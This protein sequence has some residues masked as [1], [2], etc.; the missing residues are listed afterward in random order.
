M[1]LLTLMLLGILTSADSL[2]FMD[3]SHYGVSDVVDPVLIHSAHI[4]RERSAT[5]MPDILHF[6]FELSDTEV[7]LNL[8]RS[9]RDIESYPVYLTDERGSTLQTD[10]P[11]H[12]NTAV[13]RNSLQGS[14][15]IITRKEAD[16]YQLAGTIHHN[17]QTYKIWPKKHHVYKRQA[18]ES[19]N[20]HMVAQIVSF[21]LTND[22]VDLQLETPFSVGGNPANVEGTPSSVQDSPSNVQGISNEHVQYTVELAI[23]P[24]FTDY[25]IFLA[26]AEGNTTATISNMRLYYAFVQEM[27]QIRYDTVNAQ[28]PSISITVWIK[29]INIATSAAG[30]PWTETTKNGTVVPAVPALLDHVQF[31]SANAPMSAD[32]YMIFTR[33]DLTL[34]GSPVIGVAA[35][36]ALCTDISVS[37]T[38]NIPGG[39]VGSVAAHELGHILGLQHDSDIGCNDTDRFVMAASL[40][41]ASPQ[42]PSNPW[43]F[44]SC[45]VETLKTTLSTPQSACALNTSISGS[46]LSTDGRRAGQ[47]INSDQQCVAER[48]PQ[49][50]FCRAVSPYENGNNF[51]LMCR[52]QYCF[53]AGNLCYGRFPSEHTSCGDKK[54]CE[55]GVCVSNAAAPAKS[56]KCPQGD[57]PGYGCQASKCATYAAFQLLLCCA[58]CAAQ[59]PQKTTTV[60]FVVFQTLPGVQL[61]G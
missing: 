16:V 51:E 46:I 5:H 28:D 43:T 49:S 54:W 42:A 53:G 30:S 58:T 4:R 14:A 59:I 34:R 1:M 24:D 52:V 22:T 3:E 13:Y 35:V 40:S 11:L 55:R 9:E 39:T 2:A 41:I 27:M 20:Q 29:Y 17:N 44:S 10:L 60:R 8:T 12:D 31:L 25:T 19:R 26:S 50:W 21:D 33:Y 15:A 56:A 37:I 23:F 61:F 47:T 7:S 6:R 18:S 32:A 48:G 36:D 38:Q 45:S 57:R